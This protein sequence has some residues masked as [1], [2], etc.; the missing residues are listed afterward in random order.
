MTSRTS[1]GVSVSVAPGGSPLRTRGTAGATGAVTGWPDGPVSGTSHA[2]PV[3]VSGSGCQKGAPTVKPAVGSLL[4][5]LREAGSGRR[6]QGVPS[7]LRLACAWDGAR[8]AQRCAARAR[9]H[10][11]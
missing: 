1:A 9:A 7:V 4:A 11:L 3:T 2:P 6:A 8:G 10:A 5:A